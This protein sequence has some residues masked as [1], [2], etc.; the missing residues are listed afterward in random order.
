MQNKM[1]SMVESFYTFILRLGFLVFLAV[2]QQ[3]NLTGFSSALPIDI[4]PME[5]IDSVAILA[6]FHVRL[7]KRT[8]I[9]TLQD[10]IERIKH[11]VRIQYPERANLIL[12][13]LTDEE[14][15][16]ITKDLPCPLPEDLKC[17]YKS[18]NGILVDD[19]DYYNR[20]FIWDS[21]ILL[22]L[23]EAM[24]RWNSWRG[25]GI[26]KSPFG[27][28]DFF[29][30]PDPKEHCYGSNCF[31]FLSDEGD[32]EGYAIIDAN[33]LENCKVVFT[34]KQD[35]II[36]KYKS[37]TSFVQTLADWY[38]QG[39]STDTGIFSVSRSQ[40]QKYYQVW[41]KYND[42]T[43]FDAYIYWQYS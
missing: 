9:S 19:Y 41:C 10:S 16:R 39:N 13:G 12:P 7:R 33:N 18:I 36:R 29:L 30:N 17:F 26:R 5:L 42:F 27:A 20:L 21:H 22:P 3:K 8:M 6:Y 11:S 34:I 25:E 38:E 32:G 23:Q 15:T 40:Q 28:R 24:N 4:I 31:A 2:W 14:I 1:K 35:Q 37:L 43:S